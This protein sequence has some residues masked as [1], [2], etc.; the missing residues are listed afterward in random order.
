MAGIRARAGWRAVATAVALVA[1]GCGVRGDVAGQATPRHDATAPAGGRT[2]ATGVPALPGDEALAA[3]DRALQPVLDAGTGRYRSSFRVRAGG[4]DTFMRSEGEWDDALGLDEVHVEVAD[5]G[6]PAGGFT[7]VTDGSGAAYMRNP[8]LTEDPARPWMR[9]G[10]EDLPPG[11]SALLRT[12]ADPAAPPTRFV[13]VLQHA[14]AATASPG[15]LVV[16]V[17]GVVAL[18]LLGTD[19]LDGAGL[20]A[21]DVAADLPAS[22]EVR[23][24]LDDDGHLVGGSADLVELAAAVARAINDLAPGGDTAGMEVTYEEEIVMLGGPVHIPVPLPSQVV[25]ADAGD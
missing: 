4:T 14:L 20:T 19:P 18:D 9:F 21:D 25:E 1:G 12:A 11:S 5:A 15:G 23:V 17:D 22:V 24:A 8:G 7:V 2:A 16:E 6:E 13:G 10:P 3:L